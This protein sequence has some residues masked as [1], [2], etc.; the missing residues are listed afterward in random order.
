M[1]NA[2]HTS[3]THKSSCI[4]HHHKGKQVYTDGRQELVKAKWKFRYCPT[5]Q[6]RAS[7]STA[8]CLT[9]ATD[10]RQQCRTHCHDFGI[11]ADRSL[12]DITR[13]CVS[14]ACEAAVE[15]EVHFISDPPIT[16]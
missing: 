6:R 13:L 4:M 14:S 10:K 12:E 5:A 1:S 2:E 8:N 9:D 7:D 11:G 16:K 3:R 15:T